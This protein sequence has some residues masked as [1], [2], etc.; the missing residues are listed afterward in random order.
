[1][2]VAAQFLKDP[3]ATLDFSVDWSRWLQTNETISAVTWTVATG[4]TNT[5]TS[6]TNTAATIWLS[7][8]TAGVTYSITCKITTNQ[9]RIDQ[10]TFSVAVVAR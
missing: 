2:S 8:G 3:N 7:G 6:N 4:I 5:L 9:T 1:M 10:R